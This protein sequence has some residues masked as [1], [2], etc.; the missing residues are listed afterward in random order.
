MDKVQI[1]P[2][3]RYPDTYNTYP[4]VVAAL[5]SQKNYISLHLNGVYADAAMGAWFREAYAETGKKLNMG[6]ACVRFRAVEDLPLD[7]IGEVISRVPVDRFI[8][9]YEAARRK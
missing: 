4:L 1:I 5:A 3:D 2:L 7:V 9:C 6:K 8:A